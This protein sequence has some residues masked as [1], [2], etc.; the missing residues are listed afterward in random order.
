ML[1]PPR[2]LTSFTLALLTATTA[3]AAER[4]ASARGD[5]ASDSASYSWGLGIAGFSQQQPYRGIERFNVPIP[6]I[7]FENRRVRLLGPFLDLKLADLEWGG[8]QELSLGVRV[9]WFGFNGY[10]P[11][12]APMLNGMEERKAGIF[13]GPSIKWSNPLVNLSVEWMFDA[14]SES[15]GHRTR[16][17]LDRSFHLGERFRLTPGAAAIW[18][19]STYADYYYGVRGAEARADR[20]A[21]V[22]N[23]TVNTEFTLRLD[24]TIDGRQSVFG[25]M[26]YT[27]LGRNIKNS[28]LTDRAGET[29]VLMGYLYRF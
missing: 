18:L 26:Q 2:W 3:G 19:D 9:Q 13:A 11:T 12:D 1:R 21:Y 8:D 23:S 25:A 16:V 10:K 4:D 5:S 15:K 17:G 7:Y 28:P 14:S 27:A 29:M 24:Y 22:A 6:L 20:P